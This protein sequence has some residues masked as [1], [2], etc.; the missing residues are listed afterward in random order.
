MQQGVDG[1]AHLY[2]VEEVAP[3][4]ARHDRHGYR[5]VRLDARG[6]KATRTQPSSAR[7][8]VVSQ[9]KL[10]PQRAGLWRARRVALVLPATSY[11]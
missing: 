2:I 4:A 6:Q 10:V 9:A 8:L 11:R 7:R 5:Q 3:T 1:L